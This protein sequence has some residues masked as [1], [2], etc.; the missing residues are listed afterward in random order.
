MPAVATYS[1]TTDPYVNG[2]LGDLKWAG[3]SFTYSFPASASYYGFSYGDGEP[4]N[5]FETLDPA[6]RAMTRSALTMYAS[7][8][9][10]TFTE[11]GE[12]AI[13]HGDL[14]FAMSDLPNTAWA[15]FPSTRE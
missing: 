2:V 7:V 11:V 3:N 10:L 13:Q 6:Q 9:N 15:Y 4:G 5:A 12:T 14:R 1:P 8:A